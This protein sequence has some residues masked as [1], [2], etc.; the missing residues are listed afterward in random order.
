M[1]IKRLLEEKEPPSLQKLTPTPK[2]KRQTLHTDAK[3][4]QFHVPGCESIRV[5]NSKGAYANSGYNKDEKS[6]TEQES[7]IDCN[8]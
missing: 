3:L 5:R 7:E 6:N 4:T 2:E 1:E 8:N